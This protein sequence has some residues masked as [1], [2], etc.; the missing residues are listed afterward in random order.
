MSR[1]KDEPVRIEQKRYGF[2]PNAFVWRG[3][4]YDVR[5]VE[6]YWTLARGARSRRVERR[7]FRVRHDQGTL[8]LYHDLLA[9]TWWVSAPVCRP[10]SAISSQGSAIR[11]RLRAR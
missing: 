8:E 3:R 5:Q 4:R 7:Y 9:N 6:R 2:L 11:S 10:L 1:G